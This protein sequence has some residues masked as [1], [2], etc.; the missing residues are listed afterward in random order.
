MKQNLVLLCDY[1]LDDA[2]A[3]IYLLEH[4]H[5]FDKIDILAVS[6]NSEAEVSYKNAKKLLS[7]FD[8]DLTGVR[9]VD[10]ASVP[11]YYANLPSIHGR[12]G[13]G[14]ILREKPLGIPTLQYD[15]WLKSAPIPFT[16]VSLGP[17][18]IAADIVRRLGAKELLIMGGC[19][20]EAPNF[21]GYE[22]NHYLDI[23][24]FSE[25]LHYPHVCATLDSCRTPHFNYA[26]R[27]YPTE[28]LLDKLLKRAVELAVARHP[29][30]CYVYDYIAVHYLVCPEKF[31]TE[32]KTDSQRN[33]ITQLKWI[34]EQP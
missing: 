22:F 31:T 26:A 13:M 8:G 11:Q 29:D 15:E 12:D 6:G 3:T 14:S 20:D 28:T 4:R 25:L 2:C 19:V 1:G 10:T 33:T 5:R 30:N 21:N 17:A 7:N 24:A 16:L 18:T 34:G 27:K 23:S 32:V 9:L